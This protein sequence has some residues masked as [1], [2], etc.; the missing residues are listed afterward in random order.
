VVV[1]WKTSP[2][3]VNGE[4]SKAP[5]PKVAFA[6][7]LLVEAIGDGS[8]D[9]SENIKTGNSSSIFGG[10]ALRGVSVGGSDVGLSSFL[11]L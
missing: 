9:N 8:I 3:I 1:N 6:S 4:I 10:L 5:P 11:H 7:D 2:S